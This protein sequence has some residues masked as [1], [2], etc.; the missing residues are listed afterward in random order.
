MYEGLKNRSTGLGKLKRVLQYL[1]G[2]LG[3][4]RFLCADNMVNLMAWLDVACD[5]HDD[6]RIQTGCI[7][8]FGST[9]QKLNTK[10]LTKSE[11]DGSS[12]YIPGVVW[13]EVFLKHQGIVLE[14]NEFF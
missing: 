11:V 12:D 8:S 14:T 13:A 1:K 10:S 5:V 4:P 6:T 9:K 3:V 2:M 7:V